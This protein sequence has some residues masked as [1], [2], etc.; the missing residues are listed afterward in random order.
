MQEAIQDGCGD[1]NVSD[2]LAPI[3]QRLD[4]LGASCAL[5]AQTEAKQVK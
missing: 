3:Y 4:N 2:Q 1:G 5:R